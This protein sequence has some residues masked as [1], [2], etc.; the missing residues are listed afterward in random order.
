ME[1]ISISIGF[2]I[3]E[4]EICVETESEDLPSVVKLMRGR[5]ILTDIT[6]VDL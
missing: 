4:G 5:R 6:G 1:H 2:T 3:R